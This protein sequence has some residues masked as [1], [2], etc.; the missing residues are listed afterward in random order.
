MGNRI[1]LGSGIYL[2]LSGEKKISEGTS[3]RSLSRLILLLLFT[4]VTDVA[5][6]YTFELL[7][8][9]KRETKSFSS[10]LVEPWRL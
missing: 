10:R 4:I 8:C 6:E 9:H 5:E 2:H 1:L 3:D 7:Q